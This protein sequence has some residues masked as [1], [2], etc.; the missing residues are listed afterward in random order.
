MKV[1]M[2]H[3]ELNVNVTF[4]LTNM[5]KGKITYQIQNRKCFDRSHDFW[6]PGSESPHN[7]AQKFDLKINSLGKSV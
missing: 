6:S 1:C 3:Q 2:K 5:T 7:K 4:N